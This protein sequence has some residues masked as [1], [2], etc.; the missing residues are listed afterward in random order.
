MATLMPIVA[1]IAG[2]SANQTTALIIRSLVLGQ[3]TQDNARRLL[4]KELAI[5]ALKNLY[6]AELRDW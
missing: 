5:S 3:I 1:G 4:M 6:G 2:N